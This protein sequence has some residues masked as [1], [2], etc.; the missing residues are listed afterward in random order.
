MQKLAKLL[1]ATDLSHR[2]DRAMRR[3]F[4]LAKAHDA[5]L[6]V[7]SVLDDELPE[8]MIGE[9]HARAERRLE[10]MCE[11]LGPGVRHS[12]DLR[13]GDPS[14]ELREAQQAHQP[15]LTVIGVHRTRNFFDALRET[16]MMRL[17]RLSKTAV[18]LAREPA[19]EAYDQVVA[20]VDFS[21]ACGVALALAHRLAPA[22]QVTPVHAVHVPYASMM[23]SMAR[24]EDELTRAY[25]REAT[26][27]AHA[28]SMAQHLPK[29]RLAPV[30][31][32]VG[33][34]Y[35]SL[36]QAVKDVGATLLCA[37]AH[38]RASA[39]PAVIGAVAN[40]LMRDPPCDLLIARPG[41]S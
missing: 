8:D 12:I 34:P 33:A 28:W 26:A 4:A 38:G 10:G 3:A 6:I 40:D 15:D 2:S 31:V 22:A 9:L 36:H 19:E 5:E 7:V 11:T 17:V 41:L 32:A 30:R 1:V 23:S 29:G 21:P 16:T 37:G 24:G 27:E 35:N 20:A 18:L 14:E 39:A 13:K 25:L